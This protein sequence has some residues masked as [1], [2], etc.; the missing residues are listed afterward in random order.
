[1]VQKQQKYL[2]S[3]L[4]RTLLGTI[5]NDA[6]SCFD[7]MFCNL[8]MAISMYCGIPEKFCKL[9]ANNLRLSQYK[10]RT[11]LGDSQGS[12]QHSTTTPI[13]GT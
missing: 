3:K 9:L 7:R 1:V 2:Y 4:T 10:I 11:A 8:A 5:N 6:K 12:Y 13:H